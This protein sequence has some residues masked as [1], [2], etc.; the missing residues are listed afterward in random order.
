MLTQINRIHFFLIALCIILTCSARASE[1]GTTTDAEQ[2][3]PSVSSEVYK[4]SE[5]S[6]LDDLISSCVKLFP[7]I[8]A[9]SDTVYD[10]SIDINKITISYL[11]GVK[12]YEGV[13]TLEDLI[14]IALQNNQLIEVGK[15]RWV[16]SKGQ[17]TQAISGYLP[18]LALDGRY[19]YTERKDSAAAY[20]GP[21]SGNGSS[22]SNV[23]AE[24][25]ESSSDDNIEEDD[26]VH[27]AVRFSQLLYDFG[28]TTG[29]IDIG[30]SNLGA[31]GAALQRQVQN[32]IF[33]VK[34][35]YYN[36]LEKRRLIDV[37]SESAKSFQQ[38]LDRAKIYYKAGIRTRIDVINA[39]VEL[40]NA[41]MSLLRSNY[42]LKTA[43]V[44][45]E[46]VLGVQPNHG[47]YALQNDEVHLDS[48][49]ESMPVIQDTIDQLLK[50]GLVQRPDIIQTSK[51]V[52]AAEANFSRVKGD[53]WPRVTAEAN[54]NDYDTK[55]DLY[56]DSWEVGVAATWN[57][58][59]GFHTK[60]AVSEARGQLLENKALLKDLK[61][62]VV[63]EITESFLQADEN[64]E[65]VEI[66]LQTLELAKENVA[67]AEKRY[68]SGAYDVIEFNDAQLSLTRTRNEL[69]ATYYGYLTALAEIENAV[70]EKV[71][72]HLPKEFIGSE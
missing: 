31:A 6:V 9:T 49:L 55:L 63:R 52:E 35:A 59:S 69:V 62:L 24:E 2:N 16:Q 53:Y 44:S 57:I 37:A 72:F 56:K 43:R 46:Q 14:L 10:N 54:Y 50:K 42:N 4:L 20:Q 66:A 17:L 40:S 15:Q 19:S 34:Q 36:V 68:N 8:P 12:D 47:R 28:K 58:F 67:L 51:L 38:H 30:K 7:S 29:A 45:L 48:I 22:A 26:V 25:P 18:Q 33:R 27:G 11:G 61:L 5:L 65:S 64:R 23:G 70:G 3:K 60:G 21:S 39:E 32:I 71:E 13:L 41:K 1:L